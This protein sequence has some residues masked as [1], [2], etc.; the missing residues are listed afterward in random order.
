MRGLD[1]FKII[2]LSAVHR[3]QSLPRS[4]LHFALSLFDNFVHREGLPFEVSMGDIAAASG[5]SRRASIAAVRRL[6]RARLL[7]V[8]HFLGYAA[9]NH[10]LPLA[11]LDCEQPQ[12]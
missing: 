10:F 9:K 7:Q 6:E 5:L 11:P 2:W 12:K 3:C 8:E 4:D 1:R